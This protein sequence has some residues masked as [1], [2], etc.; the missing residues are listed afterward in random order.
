MKY[1]FLY[2]GTLGSSLAAEEIKRLESEAKLSKTK[3]EES[4]KS[5]QLLESQGRKNMD[6]TDKTY[7]NQ[8]GNPVTPQV[9]P[10]CCHLIIMIII[11][12]VI[13]IILIIIIITIMIIVIMVI[14]IIIVIIT[15]TAPQVGRGNVETAQLN[16]LLTQMEYSETILKQKCLDSEAKRA[17]VER[18]KQSLIDR[19]EKFWYRHVYMYIYKYI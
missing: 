6:N 10:G 19:T 4:Q 8:S 17:A 15:I 3:Y 14:I 16:A 12:V 7:M 13:T 9:G 18:E 11:I 5:L 2:T 1:T